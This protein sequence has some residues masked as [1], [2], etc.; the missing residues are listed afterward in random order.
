MNPEPA[1]VGGS[2]PVLTLHQPWASLVACGAKRIETRSWSTTYRGPL[3]IHAGLQRPPRSEFEGWLM[4]GPV[5]PSQTVEEMIQALGVA[6]FDTLPRGAVVAVAE[7]TRCD[8]VTNDDAVHAGI[9]RAVGP[10]LEKARREFLCGDY[11]VN[12]WMWLLWNVTPLPTPVAWRGQ[13]RL[14]AAPEELMAQVRML[15]PTWEPWDA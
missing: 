14:W 5:I 15:L 6:D 11:S 10:S 2:M 3:L 8:K 13:R 7:C 1:P 4:G 9:W 12:R